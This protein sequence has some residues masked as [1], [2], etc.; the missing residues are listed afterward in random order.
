[1]AL[2]EPVVEVQALSC[3]PKLPTVASDM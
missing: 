2:E 3:P 1:M